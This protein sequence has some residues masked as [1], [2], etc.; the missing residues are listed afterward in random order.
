VL[1]RKGSLSATEG[2]DKV[3]RPV[4][5]AR[6][7]PFWEDFPIVPCCERGGRTASS[8][9]KKSNDRKNKHK[10]QFRGGGV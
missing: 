8:Y 7:S 5:P 3:K 6:E 4:G 9:E 10:G 1:G 2:G